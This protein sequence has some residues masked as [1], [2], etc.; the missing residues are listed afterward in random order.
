MVGPLPGWLKLVQKVGG[1][2]RVSGSLKD[3]A[4]VVAEH[5]KPIFDIGGVLF[6]RFGCQLEVCAQKGCAELCD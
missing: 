1:A 5:L 4:L 2:L 6:A 3:C